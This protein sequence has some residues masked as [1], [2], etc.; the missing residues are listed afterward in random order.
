[1]APIRFHLKH[2]VKQNLIQQN[3]LHQTT[4]IY[5]HASLPTDLL[6]RSPRATSNN[7]T[8]SLKITQL[9]NEPQQKLANTIPL[10]SHIPCFAANPPLPLVTDSSFKVKA[11]PT[12]ETKLLSPTTRSFH[13]NTKLAEKKTSPMRVKSRPRRTEVLRMRS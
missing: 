13:S 10:T 8:P 2:K 9:T 3:H 11:P 7:T 4:K 1:M 12:T 5:I 6:H